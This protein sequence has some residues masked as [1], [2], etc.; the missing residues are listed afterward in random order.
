MHRR[1]IRLPI[2]QCLICQKIF[3]LLHLQDMM[4]FLQKITTTNNK[5]FGNIT[6]LC[7]PL[8]R[9]SKLLSVNIYFHKGVVL[10][11]PINVNNYIVSTLIASPVEFGERK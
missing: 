3:K 1:I 5:K 4:A 7:R 10:E 2:L 9:T 8:N 6:T 11:A